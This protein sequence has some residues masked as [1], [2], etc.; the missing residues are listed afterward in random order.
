MAGIDQRNPCPTEMMPVF[1]VRSW[2]VPCRPRALSARAAAAALATVL[3]AAPV[4]ATPAGAAAAGGAPSAVRAHA[5]PAPGHPAAPAG[6]WTAAPAGR[7]GD[8]VQPLRSPGQAVAE[9]ARIY[10]EA[11]RVGR[12]YERAKA[13]ADRQRATL[14]RLTERLERQEARYRELRDAVGAVAADQYRTGGLLAG[15]R[16][17]LADSPEAF[18]ASSAHMAR[19]NRAAARLAETADET[20]AEL[21]GQRAAAERAL[22]R[23]R[24]KE[25]RQR[26]LKAR[27]DVELKRARERA[28]RLGDRPERPAPA[29]GGR[30]GPRS[31]GWVTPVAAYRLTAGY[32]ATGALW[33]SGHTGQDF[34]VRTGTPVRSVGAGTV[35]RAGYAGPYGYQVVIRHGDGFHTVYAHLSV[36]QTG[37]GQ[38]V[39]AGERIALSGSTGNSSGPHLHFEVRRG[40]AGGA[41]VEPVSWLRSRGVRV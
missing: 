34:A 20:R 12:G 18:L 41:A 36:L 38:R 8:R 4:G 19:N 21:A 1:A 32:A 33:S 15:A 6:S 25:E 9:A 24:A 37:V 23:L 26:E 3:G 2:H 40:G 17:V 10:R 5:A 22:E 28:A 31:A 14:D 30:G 29:A 35:V 27:I 39:A 13:A 16:A 11:T 7:S